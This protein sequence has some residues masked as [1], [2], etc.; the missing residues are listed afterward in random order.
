MEARERWVRVSLKQKRIRAFIGAVGARV[1]DPKRI[2]AFEQFIVLPFIEAIERRVCVSM[3]QSAFEH[4]SSL[5]S[6]HL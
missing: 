1:P 3:S 6:F 5:L 4:S 2:R